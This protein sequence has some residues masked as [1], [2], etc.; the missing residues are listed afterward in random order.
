MGPGAG[1]PP[2]PT[3]S[4]IDLA[5]VHR[6]TRE[7]PTPGGVADLSDLV[8]DRARHADLVPLSVFAWWLLSTGTD[9]A[10]RTLVVPAPGSSP[11]RHIARAGVITASMQRGLEI[12][13]AD[14]VAFET[15]HLHSDPSRHQGRLPGVDWEVLDELTAAD[16]LRIIVD[17]ADDRRKVPEQTTAVLHYPWLGNLGLESPA[18]S[19]RGYRRFLADADTALAELIDNVH[20]WS[21]A[22]RAFAVAS[23]T[24][25]GEVGGTERL[26]WNRLH[27]VIA[28]NGVGVPI[29][30]REDV[31]ASQAVTDAAVDGISS[32]DDLS[33]SELLERLLLY[34]FG[35][36]RLKNHNGH[37][38]NA[39][40][41]R[42]GQWVGAVD[43]FTVGRDGSVLRKGSRGFDPTLGVELEGAK[44]PSLL[45]ARG[46]LVHVLLQATDDR[47][48][49]EE[50][51]GQEQLPFQIHDYD[52]ATAF[53]YRELA[54]A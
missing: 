28:D 48:R 11:L 25:G 33:D 17:L 47:D 30:L 16:R 37:G 15:S 9:L 38:L 1:G 13:H 51:A 50:A 44:D 27:L 39:T 2:I 42:A 14:G 41:I 6:A 54:P 46:T 20:R 35:Y 22:T 53:A 49:R 24:R 8:H 19:K 3:D 45:G 34:A 26:S 36:R 23:V 52:E 32:P 21:R 5:W 10:G 4:L 29:A 43:V 40:Q 18:I 31:E 12:R 7:L